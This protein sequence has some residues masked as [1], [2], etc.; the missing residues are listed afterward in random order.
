MCLG[1]QYYDKALLASPHGGCNAVVFAHSTNYA[2]APQ[3]YVIRALPIL[4]SPLSSV[5]VKVPPTHVVNSSSYK[6]YVS[7]FN[8]PNRTAIS[9]AP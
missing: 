7:V 9:S 1:Q 4:L 3:F 6:R 2:N 5:H 8:H